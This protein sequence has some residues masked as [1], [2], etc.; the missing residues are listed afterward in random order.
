[1]ILTGNKEK[2]VEYYDNIYSNCYNTS[3]YMILYQ[4][5]TKIVSQVAN[6][7]VLELGCG[8]GDLGELLMKQGTQY[9][10]FDFSEIAVNQCL[11]K[12]PQGSF[13][14][15][16]VYDHESFKPF[17]YNIAIALEVLEHINDLEVI[18]HLPPGCTF[19]ASVPDYNDP[20]HLRLYKDRQTDIVEHF[21]PYL[22]ITEIRSAQIQKGSTIHL[23]TGIRQQD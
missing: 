4:E 20:A 16:N 1:M 7:S 15:G 17:D 18:E 6:P 14:V 21:K 2:D 22:H 12:Y 8:L 3:N 9:R 5:V 23:F 13:K 10:G 11:K 19:I